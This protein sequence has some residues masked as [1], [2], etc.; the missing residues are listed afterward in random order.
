MNIGALCHEMLLFENTTSIL[1]T[2]VPA[3][4]F[5][6]HCY[7]GSQYPTT[8]S[9]SDHNLSEFSMYSHLYFHVVINDLI[10]IQSE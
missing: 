1:D 8:F 4:Y 3:I 10:A 6:E 2:W 9:G 7:T 5:S